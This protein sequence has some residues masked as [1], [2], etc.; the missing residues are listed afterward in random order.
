MIVTS[1]D[2]EHELRSRFDIKVMC[3]LGEISTAPSKLFKLLNPAY[4]EKYEPNQ[5]L[6]FYTSHMLPK[7]I[8]QH[9]YETV[10]FLDI[11]NWFILICGPEEIKDLV[12]SS[13]E[14]F[15]IDPI[16]FQ[17]QSVDLATTH[18][19]NDAFSLPDTICAIPWMNLEI[20]SD[21]NI[22]PCCMSKN[23]TLGNIK[24]ITLEQAFHGPQAQKLRN[25]LL[26]GEKPD[27]CQYC[28]RVEERNLTSIRLHNI[29]RIKKDFLSQYLDE[30]T[31]ATVDI[32]F[33]N[34]C[35]FKCRICGGQ[36]S[37]LFAQEEHKFS[38]RSL[39]IQN[40]W[41]E[42]QD[43]IDQINRHLPDIKNIDLYGGE[44]FLIK[45]FKKVLKMAVDQGHA[46]NI[47][48]H[49]NSNGSIWPGEFLP[50][51]TDF[52]LVDIHFSI[53]AVGTR[54]E[55]ERGGSWAEVEK[56]ILNLK[57]LNL[58]NLSISIMPTISVMNVYYIDQV[59][60]WATR[61]GFLIFVSHARGIGME[62]KYLTA[63]AKQLILEKFKDHPWDEM[64]KILETIQT[65]PGSDGREFRHRIKWFDTIRNENFSESH[66]EIA[67]AMKY[68]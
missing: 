1:V 22:T 67:S 54:F 14:K 27:A 48:L 47:R 40:N 9:L 6:V 24:D 30:P 46:K 21:G 61:H 41:G 23:L 43:F 26:N 52:K 62:L 13:C 4:Q 35:N 56:N 29:R 53:D 33:N 15:S 7:K 58:P 5:R 25:S 31:L 64:Q 50:Y 16:P 55:L 19:I 38:G 2:L 44:P 20:Q 28:W 63:Q 8:M 32:K 12:I 51:W 68:M 66:P 34:T 11:S 42:S 60:D 37:S 65:L 3:D 57:N 45:K 39:I 10:N 17:F 36:N 49:Y 59:Y 18:E